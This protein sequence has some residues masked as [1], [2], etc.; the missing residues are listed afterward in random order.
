M[1]WITKGGKDPLYL[2]QLNYFSSVGEK[3]TLTSTK[4]RK[5]FIY[6][7]ILYL[8]KNY[9]SALENRIKHIPK[10]A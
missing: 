5:P 6:I 1:H 9:V 3:S 2:N 4:V 10:N 8:N 7:Y